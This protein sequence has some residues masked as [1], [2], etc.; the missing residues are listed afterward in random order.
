LRFPR[1]S[2]ILLH[3]TSFAGRYGIGD[4]G[5]EAYHFVD[6][7]VGARQSIWQVLPL[8]PTGYGDSPYQ[9]FSAFAGNPLLISPDKLVEDGLLTAGDVRRVPSFPA[10]QV[11]Y[12]RVIPY[13]LDLLRLA[14]RRFKSGANGSIAKAFETFCHRE[15]GWLDDFALFMALKDAHQGA[16]WNTWA[17]DIAKRAPEALRR[18][19]DRLAGEVFTYKFM[20]FLFFRQWLALKQYANDHGIRIVG[21]IPIFVAYDS[22]DVWSHPDLFFLDVRGNLTVQA[23]VPPD[24]FT[25]TG[26]LWGNPLYRWD[27][28]A[29][30]GFAWWIDRFRAMF[31]QVDILRLDHF[32]GF[33]R[34]WEVPAS[35]TTAIDGKWVPGP[36]EGIFIAVEKALGTLPIIAEDLGAITPQVEAL[37][38]KFEFP[39]M[40]LIQFAFTDDADN[41][42][43]PHNYPNNC[44]VY[45]GTHDNDTSRGWFQAAPPHERS[46]A[47]RYLARSGEDIAYDFI[48]AA[49]SSVADTAVV[50][51]QDVLALGSE[52]RMNF[53]GR[54]AGNWGWRF[55]P[56]MLGEWQTSRLRDMVALYS[57]EP[58]KEKKNKEAFT[59]GPKG[60][61]Q[62]P[63]GP[64]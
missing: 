5:D 9:C 52:A 51:L 33:T 23:G 36:G 47:Q 11:D 18:W 13:K 53:P 50:P 24:V 29:K 43:L 25:E 64:A 30:Q 19:G 39:G 8:G 46:F 59:A 6:F 1:S 26:Q 7:L 56:D 14:A 42:F 16:V 62:N 27:V 2:G 41:P 60:G 58:E 40:K 37:R 49:M 17:E 22:A 32:I 35:E 12:G 21:D 38:D 45:T 48:R 4:L 44:V 20:Q 10:D 55:R 63:S 54:P 15:A 57:R 3:P 61:S 31:T 34:Y 28:M